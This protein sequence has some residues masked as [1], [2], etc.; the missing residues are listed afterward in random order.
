MLV[1]ALTAF[2]ERHGLDPAARD[3]L[4]ALVL[5]KP[6]P[7]ITTLIEAVSLDDER[8]SADGS[9]PIALASGEDRFVDLGLLGTGGMGEVR[10]VRDVALNRVM[11]M[12]IVHAR[13]LDNPRL[14]ARFLEEAQVAAQ[15]Q[16][17]GIP[18]V[19]ELGLL[20]DGRWFF[21]MKE[22]VG[23][24]LTE[25]IRDVHDAGE[26]DPIAQ[27]R[28]IDAFARV[29]EAL[30]YAHHRGVVH[31]DLKPDNILLGAFGEVL[32]VDWG[33]AKV[34]GRGDDGPDD[35]IT[36][37]SQQP[38]NRTRTGTIA[39]TAPYMPPEQ[40]RGQIE[41]VDARSDVYALGAVL[42]EV[43]AGRPPYIGRDSKGILEQVRAGPPRPLIDAVPAPVAD[44][45]VLIVETAMAREPEKRPANAGEV[46]AAVNAWLEG[47]K[48]R[49]HALLA[50]DR[51]RSRM[52]LAT[53]LRARA[54]EMRELARRMLVNVPPWEPED[55]KFA[56]WAR[57]DEAAELDRT[58]MVVEVEGEGLL[59]GA[60]AEVAD[61]A[62]AHEALAE[63]HRAEHVA[64]EASR[65]AVAIARAEALLLAHTS[66]LPVGNA[67]RASN[68]AYLQGDGKLTLHT[69][70]PAVVELHRYERFHRRLVTVFDRSLDAPIID[71]RLPMGSYLCVI[72]APGRPDVR[73]P[74]WIRRSEAWHGCP[75]GADR[76][77]PIGIPE[78]LSPGEC[79]VPAGWFWCGGDPDALESLPGG[80]RWC[81]G[82]AMRQNPVTNTE[83]LAFLDDL[84]ATGREDDALRYVPR[85]R[86]GSDLADG[87]MIYGRRADGGFELT[88][89]GDGDV[90]GLD[91]PVF[92]VDFD[93][94]VAY[95]TWLAGRTGQPWRLPA[96]VEWEKAARG[97]DGRRFPWGDVLDPSWC[98]MRDSQR[99]RPLPVS[100]ARF[101]VDESPYGVRGMA[102]NTRDWTA[103]ADDRVGG[104]VDGLV[105]RMIGR[106]GSWLSDARN[107][108]CASRQA[109]TRHNRVSN[110]GFR[111]ARSIWNADRGRT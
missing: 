17:P 47:V 61:L 67:A 102:G 83:Y 22:V 71:L 59:R 69:D 3:E 88:R 81:D 106:G 51:A 11:A 78:V 95:A 1:P 84:A 19:H 57:E 27:R 55:L 100:V 24:T 30:A 10:R 60:L 8:P 90:W 107:C 52:P 39:G 43:L 36:D 72:R 77:L 99:G 104:V 23:R 82:F 6:A 35:V 103:D 9:E 29:C 91:F 75:S 49:E 4:I 66:P 97:V 15:L 42:Y 80:W 14:V 2:A 50:V 38:A 89:D 25:L 20:A 41:R 73:Y 79:Y 74:V 37:R 7:T 26:P 12:K 76:P 85:E 109:V 31:R 46:A 32:L 16:H 105:L 86:A 64:A 40:A 98:C 87:A 44:D 34:R 5:H 53:S 96:E 45:L 101:P 108:R 58:A 56:A 48:R 70:V 21:T 18:P 110:L 93:S 33:L 13:L 68:L 62:E 92:H 65:D 111:V 54:A 63:R 28:L 94:A